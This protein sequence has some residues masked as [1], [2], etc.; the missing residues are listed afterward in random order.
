[1]SAKQVRFVVHGDVVYGMANSVTPFVGRVG[2][3]A[4]GAA[5]QA[6]GPMQAASGSRGGGRKC[7]LTINGMPVATADSIAAAEDPVPIQARPMT[8]SKGIRLNGKPLLL[9]GGAF[10]ASPDGSLQSMALTQTV[11]FG[12]YVPPA[13]GGEPPPMPAEGGGGPNPGAAVVRSNYDSPSAEHQIV[14]RCSSQRLADLLPPEYAVLVG[15]PVDVATGAVVTSA[16]DDRWETP[17]L[18]FE[19]RYSSR[20]SGRDGPLGPG[21]SHNFDQAI[22]LEEGRVVLR[23]DGREIEFDCFELLDRVAR[24]GDV[25]HDLTG[26]LTL[27]CHGHNAWELSDGPTTRHFLPMPGVAAADRDRGLSL[28]STIVRPE[29]PLIELHY[30]DRARLNSVRVDGRSMFAF[31]YDTDDHIESLNDR[32]VRYRYSAAGDLI[33]AADVEGHARKY[34]YEGHLLVRETNRL[35]GEFFYGYDGHGSGAKC[36]RTWGTGG[37]L[38]RMLAYE[39]SSTLVTDSLGNRT[40]YDLSPMGLV[41]GIEDP[42]GGKHQFTYDDQLRLTRVAYPDGTEEVDLYDEAGRRVKHRGRDGATWRMRYDDGGRLQEGFDPLG[43]RWVFDHDLDGRLSRVED[44]LGHVTRLAYENRRLH[45]IT[46]PLGRVTS[47]QLGAHDEVLVVRAP[48]RPAM[49]FEYDEQG[50]LSRCNTEHGDEVRW[51]HDAFGRLVSVSRGGSAVHWLRDVEGHVTSVER[52]DRFENY[53]RDSFGRL[54]GISEGDVQIGYRYDTEDQLLSAAVDGQPRVEFRYDERGL[55]DAFVIDRELEGAVVREEK[56]SRIRRLRTGDVTLSLRWDEGGRLAEFDDGRGART[57][58]YR[59]DGLL[60]EYATAEHVCVLQRDAL[61]AVTQQRQGERCID[62]AQLD[63]AGNRYGVD[64]GDALGISYL[65]GGHGQLERIA[66]VSEDPFELEVGASMDGSGGVARHA[67][68][69]VEFR[70]AIAPPAWPAGVGPDVPVDALHRPLRGAEDT[71]LLWDEGRLLLEGE[72]VHICDPR[73]DVRLATATG[74]ALQLRQEPPPSPPEDTRPTAVALAACR[75]GEVSEQGAEWSEF[76]PGGLLRSAF[77]RQRW[78]PV[79]RP[80]PGSRPWQ[81]DAW[82]PLQL[83]PH[84]ATTRLDAPALLG[85]LSPF[86]IPLLKTS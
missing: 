56:G 42:E 10:M 9:H 8:M 69:E 18:A 23:C 72:K 13:G 35:G 19:R 66:V 82:Q 61:G 32:L 52:P 78:N 70:C 6:V 86:P 85:L 3:A 81:P 45:E 79:V 39:D 14:S 12:P 31:R 57:F 34:A 41:T 62:S 5:K 11:A 59:E 75:L 54:L 63:H 68:R 64:V 7:R 77:A 36:V 84:V 47:L 27:T 51:F 24:A 26:R 58:A 80:Q 49:K 25:L 37:R 53:R 73:Y 60:V 55:V 65:W 38:H 28:L 46:D 22:W 15:D 33:E 30:D 40:I 74:S 67:D 29:Q 50:R 20:R 21:W 4:G 2:D 44:P 16:I 71:E 43:G 48:H 17:A 76:T 1:M 83:D